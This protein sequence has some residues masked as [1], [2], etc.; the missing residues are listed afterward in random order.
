[1]ARVNFAPTLPAPLLN[2]EAWDGVAAA[3]NRL[4]G[5]VRD[6]RIGNVVVLTG[7]VHSSWVTDLKA[8][9]VDPT[10]PVVATEFVG[11]SIS[12]DFPPQF[13]A[14]I[15]AALV[16][17]ANAHVKFFDGAFRG[18]VR[19][20]GGHQAGRPTIGWSTRFWRIRRQYRPGRPS[21]CR[22]ATPERCRRRD[23]GLTADW[24]ARIQTRSIRQDKGPANGTSCCRKPGPLSQKQRISD[25][26]KPGSE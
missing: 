23:L 14:A 11:T 20:G 9:F 17:P 18:Y 6:A 7:D 15:Q 2:M 22:A 4:L 8:D 13:I 26:A 5:L 25:G 10:S 12:S 1:M 16:H 24:T 3:R 19:C 21:S